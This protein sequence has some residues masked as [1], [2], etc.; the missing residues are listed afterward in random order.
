MSC[1]STLE[2]A[3]GALPLR[4]S[5]HLFQSVQDLITAALRSAEFPRNRYS[6]RTS[7]A[8]ARTLSDLEVMAPQAGSFAIVVQSSFPTNTTSSTPP[9]SRQGFVR[10]ASVSAEMAEPDSELTNPNVIERGGSANL[11]RATAALIDAGGSTHP[12][13]LDC[14]LRQWQHRPKHHA[15]SSS[16]RSKRTHSLRLP[17]PSH[18]M[19]LDSKLRRSWRFQQAD[20]CLSCSATWLGRFAGV[21]TTHPSPR[22][23]SRRRPT[24]RARM[25]GEQST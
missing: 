2:T 20:T 4:A 24:R 10:L 19:M 5:Q 11:Y 3:K 12:V 8:I 16:L 13:R 9:L 14:G 25:R 22:L 15:A 6:G 18:P 23:P 17:P 21:S 7:Q 1:V